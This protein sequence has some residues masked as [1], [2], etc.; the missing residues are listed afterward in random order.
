ML[1]ENLTYAFS[2]LFLRYIVCYPCMC[3]SWIFFLQLQDVNIQLSK[4]DQHINSNK[5]S[6]IY[7]WGLFM[8]AVLLKI[9]CH[10]GHASAH[11]F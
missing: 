3:D 11:K 10:S 7:L 5:S 2:K 9:A 1:L 6:H 8:V 4:K